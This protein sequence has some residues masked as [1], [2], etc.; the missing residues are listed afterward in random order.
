MKRQNAT[1]HSTGQ[2][3]LPHVLHFN[4]TI[5]EVTAPHKDS[6]V[7][8]SHRMA[9]RYPRLRANFEICPARAGIGDRI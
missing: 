4:W 8:D 7:G 1:V 6:G 2:G 9:S 3:I 5:C